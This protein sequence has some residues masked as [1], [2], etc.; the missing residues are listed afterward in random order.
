MSI[1]MILTFEAEDDCEHCTISFEFDP[2]LAQMEAWDA[3]DNKGKIEHGT[4]SNVAKMVI[5]AGGG[6]VQVSNVE[7]EDLP[8]H[9]N[10]K[11]KQK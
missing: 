4:A 8:E 11:G 1:K 6:G 5:E 10:D 9:W 2:P 7:G 3:L